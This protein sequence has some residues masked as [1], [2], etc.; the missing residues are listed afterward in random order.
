MSGNITNNCR[1]FIIYKKVPSFWEKL[2][3]NKT[4][5]EIDLDGMNGKTPIH[6][7]RFRRF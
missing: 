2:T 4:Q 5:S 6:S 3:K 7:V 1:E